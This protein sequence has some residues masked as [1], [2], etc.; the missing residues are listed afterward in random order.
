MKATIFILTFLSV[1]GTLAN[2]L[3]KRADRGSETVSGISSR[4]QSILNAGGNTL[5]LAIAML[6]TETMT[7]DYTYGDGKT[8]DAANF[9]L[10]KQNWGMLRVCATRYGL[11]GQPE[12]SWNNGALLNNNVYADVAS[13]WDCQE[14]YG[15][16]KWFAGHR[17]GASGLA[18]PNTADINNYKNAVYWIQEQIDSNSAYKSDDTRFWVDVTPI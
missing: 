8:Q 16:D 18:N 14:Y 4:K 10:F 5:D 1:L 15:V 9:G 6:E 7:T 3:T 2:D 17:N 12:S 13:R 11:A